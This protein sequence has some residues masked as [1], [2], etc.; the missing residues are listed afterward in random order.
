MGETLRHFA[1]HR[2]AEAVVAPGV[3]VGV[4]GA[5]GTS[6]QPAERCAS[7][8]GQLDG[9]WANWSRQT[10][11]Q[12]R[13]D[14]GCAG[15]RTDAPW[16]SPTEARGVDG[17]TVSRESSWSPSGTARAVN[18]CWS[19]TG[20]ASIRTTTGAAGAA[21]VFAPE[22]K[23]LQCGARVSVPG[24]DTVAVAEFMRFQHLLGDRTWLDGVSMLPYGSVLRYRPETERL[25]VSRYWDWDRRCRGCRWRFG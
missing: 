11:L 13:D 10:W 4:H 6:G 25:A 12:G 7:P 20:S 22:L 15:G 21:L 9:S 24:L 3:A 17:L 18:W 14:G 8:D 1:Y 23:A 19:M 2:T 16:R 5:G